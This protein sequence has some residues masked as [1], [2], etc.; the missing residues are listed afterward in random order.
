MLL[1]LLRGS[2]DIRAQLAL[3]GAELARADAGTIQTR[4]QPLQL[5]L[6]L[7]L[8]SAQLRGGGL[9]LAELAAELARGRAGF[10]HLPGQRRHAGLRLLVALRGAAQGLLLLTVGAH[11]ALGAVEAAEGGLLLLKRAGQPLLPAI[12]LRKGAVA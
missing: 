6:L 9:G 8:L 4:T 7:L 2:G 3:V 10:I 5:H 11:I 1:H 12:T